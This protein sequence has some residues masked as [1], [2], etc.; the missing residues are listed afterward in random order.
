MMAKCEKCGKMWD[1]IKGE[2]S[3]SCCCPPAG[4]QDVIVSHIQIRF[5]AMDR[6]RIL[7]LG[8]V[9][10]NTATYTENEPGQCKSDTTVIVVFRRS[11]IMWKPFSRQIKRVLSFKRG[12]PLITTEN[13]MEDR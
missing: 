11:L 4:F 6:I 5:S 7:L 10:V 9:R 13:W 3:P 12:G 8:D 2:Y 1:W